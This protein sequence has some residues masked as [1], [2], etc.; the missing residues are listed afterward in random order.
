VSPAPS[1]LDHEISDALELFA[2]LARARRMTIATKLDASAVVLVDRDALRQVLLN[3]LDNAAKYGPSG[4]TITVGSEISG[5]HAR[6]W[7]E[8]QGPGIPH[9]DRHRVWEPYVR[10]NREAESTTGGSGI[11]L[12]VVR[13]LVT[14]HG[15]RTRA[16][17]AP[18]GGARLVIELPLTHDSPDTTSSSSPSNVQLKAVP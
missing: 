4:Q 16:E 12:S 15:G 1:D 13:E 7:V 14:M 5:D 18:G 11:G 8:D 17:S 3:L 9:E 10:L 6:V 2:P